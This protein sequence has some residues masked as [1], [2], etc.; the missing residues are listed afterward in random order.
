ML[1]APEL[2]AVLQVGSHRIRV[3]Y[4]HELQRSFQLRLI[5]VMLLLIKA[6]IQL[7]SMR[8]PYNDTYIF[9][10]GKGFFFNLSM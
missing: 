4:L 9:L 5:V 2:D 10:E 8:R 1:G 3:K 6:L 7:V